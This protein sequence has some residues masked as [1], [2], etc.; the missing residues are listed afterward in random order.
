MWLIESIR[1]TCRPLARLTQ[2]WKS[3]SRTFPSRLAQSARLGPSS[4][5]KGITFSTAGSRD[6]VAAA[7]GEQATWIWAFSSCATW[8]A[9]GMACS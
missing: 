7:A 9:A 6:Q 1:S 5:A 3:G 8:A 2:A 4:K